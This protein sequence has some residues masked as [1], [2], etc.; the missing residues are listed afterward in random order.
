MKGLRRWVQEAGSRWEDYRQSGGFVKG[1]GGEKGVRLE[2]LWERAERGK[3]RRAK[4]FLLPGSHR[5]FKKRRGKS[6]SDT[7]RGAG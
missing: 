2:V 7:Q 1:V 3:R 5:T 4:T 6:N